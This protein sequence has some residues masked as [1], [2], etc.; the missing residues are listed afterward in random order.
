MLDRHVRPTTKFCPVETISPVQLHEM[1]SLFQRFYKHAD[2]ATFMRDLSKKRGAV[3]V[4][5]ADS[6]RLLGFT[7]I[8]EYEL[9]RGPEKA[10]GVFS[11]DTIMVP[12]L[13][14]NP[15]LQNGFARYIAATKLRNPHRRVFWLIISK[16]YKTYL[17]V[18]NNF[19]SYFPR[20]DRPHDPDLRSWVDVYC[21]KLFPNHY[22]RAR[23]VL[24]FGDGS[25]ALRE[26]VA[27]ITDELKRA[28]PKI[29]FFEERNPEWQRG[30]EL[31]CIGEVT[32]SDFVRHFM[33]TSKRRWARWRTGAPQVTNQ[34]P[35]RQPQP[36]ASPAPTM[37]RSLRVVREGFRPVVAVGSHATAADSARAPW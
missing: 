15:C 12:E 1:H 35:V 31:A 4:R 6:G 23:S 25:Q 10:L 21:E 37:E 18:A 22:D 26:E 2:A 16:G 30:V 28:N 36:V 13:W 29:R 19:E 17:L 3:V 27:P 20:H 8:T 9:Q 14:G 11:G 32:M 33:K 5:D 7:T 34:A 24:D